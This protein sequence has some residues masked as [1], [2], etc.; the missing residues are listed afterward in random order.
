M[1]SETSEMD[2]NT[3]KITNKTCIYTTH[4]LGQSGYPQKARYSHHCEVRV[5]LIFECLLPA[6]YQ[7]DLEIEVSV[8]D[9]KGYTWM[10]K[11]DFLSEGQHVNSSRFTR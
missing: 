9:F 3:T 8:I 5:I 10:I 2:L 7:G 6:V 1:E 11:K 4:V